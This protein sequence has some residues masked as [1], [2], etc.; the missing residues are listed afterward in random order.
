MDAAVAAGEV[1][2]STGANTLDLADASAVASS[3]VVGIALDS[4]GIGD[5]PRIQVC[6][7]VEIAGWGLTAGSRYFLSTTAGAITV[8][9]PTAV[10]ESV[11]EIGVALS[12]TEL[13]LLPTPPILL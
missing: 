13:R 1:V 10:G 2:Y 9:A 8:T 4:G 5:S 11:V 6:G 3:S 12:A 7:V